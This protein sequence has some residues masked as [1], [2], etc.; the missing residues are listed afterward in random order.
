MSKEGFEIENML[1]GLC[2]SLIREGVICPFNLSTAL[3]QIYFEIV[4]EHA[5]PEHIQS[6]LKR[7]A[8]AINELAEKAKQ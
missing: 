5:K 8:E 6:V 7:A 2:Q 1:F 4:K 3:L